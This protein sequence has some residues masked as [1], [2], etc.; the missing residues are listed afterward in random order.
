M[1]DAT[2]NTRSLVPLRIA[3]V[4]IGLIFIFGI[5]PQTLLWPSGWRWGHGSSHYLAMILGIYATLGIFLLF[6]ARNPFAHRS[7]IWFTVVSSVVHAGIMAA[8]AIGDSAE[9]GHLV[10]DVPALLVVAVVLTL[11]M[12]RAAGTR[13]AQPSG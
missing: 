9:R 5:Y 7:L 13:Q 4:V 11:L 8:Q 2:N 3:L 10:G 1:S 12:P 6:A